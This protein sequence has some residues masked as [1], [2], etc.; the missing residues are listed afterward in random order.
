M[1]SEYHQCERLLKRIATVKGIP[2]DTMD[3][4]LESVT[5]LASETSY[6]RV[7]LLQLIWEECRNGQPI[8][9]AFASVEKVAR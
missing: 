8:H 1:Y 4:L 5:K 6:R 9:D 2:T 7:S 3:D